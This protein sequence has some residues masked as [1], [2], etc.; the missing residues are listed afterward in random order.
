MSGECTPKR[1]GVHNASEVSL[2]L[3]RST[4][5]CSAWRRHQVGAALPVRTAHAELT[6]LRLGRMPG[7]PRALL[8]AL[9]VLHHVRPASGWDFTIAAKE[10]VVCTGGASFTTT[11]ATNAGDMPNLRSG[12]PGGAGEPS[13]LSQCRLSTAAPAAITSVQ[14]DY[15]YVVGYTP[16]PGDDTKKGPVLSLSIQ[17]KAGADCVAAGVMYVSPPLPE[18]A[19]QTRHSFDHC[20]KADKK[21]CYSPAVSVDAEPAGG[22]AGRYLAIKFSNNDRNLQLLLPIAIHSALLSV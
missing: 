2:Q 9:L 22:C 7:P 1:L 19:D 6:Q 13:I 17:D 15:R 8:A 20:D 21:D 4:Y 18:G 11:G 3:V 14:L 5:I 12:D 10:D 16:E